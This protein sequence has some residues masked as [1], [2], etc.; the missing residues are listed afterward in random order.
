MQAGPMFAG[1]SPYPNLIWLW[2]FLLISAAAIISALV[3]IYRIEKRKKSQIMAIE[4]Q[5]QETTTATQRQPE[6]SDD[7]INESI[8]HTSP[9]PKTIKLS[10]SGSGVKFLRILGWLIIAVA[11]II[12]IYMAG[13]GAFDSGIAFLPIIMYGSI[14]I[15]FAG[16]CFALATIA[17]NA[18]ISTAIL[19]EKYKIEE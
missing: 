17:E 4:E 19:K 10:Y 1:S 16:I 5:P 7:S 15:L 2:L 9:A 13:A 12:I 8:Q 18:L 3:I 11:L 6:A 14:V